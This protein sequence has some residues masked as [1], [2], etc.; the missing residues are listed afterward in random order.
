ME[1]TYKP[2][3]LV[4]IRADLKCYEDNYPMHNAKGKGLCVVSDM[5]EFFGKE[6]EITKVDT[7]FDSSGDPCYR[8][9]DVMSG[10]HSSRYWTDTMFIGFASDIN[11][12]EI[13]DY[14]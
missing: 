2:G 5:S 13:D 3:D 12:F 9:K 4:V 11:A 1:T 6:I 8:V 10:R 7:N 14:I